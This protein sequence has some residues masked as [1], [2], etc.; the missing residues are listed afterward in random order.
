MPGTI[1][2]SA[3]G[4]QVVTCDAIG[5]SESRA[6]CTRGCTGGACRDE[7]VCGATIYETTSGGSWLV[8]L[9]GE[10]ADQDHT[11]ACLYHDQSP[12]GEDVLFRLE[13]DRTRTF[14]F[15]ARYS[16]GPEVIDPILYLR[17]RC[18]DRASQIWCHE[19]TAG[20]DE[21]FTETLAPGDYFLVI[22]R[23]ERAGTRCG[24]LDVSITPM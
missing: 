14:R 24:V 13:V 20:Q 1:R 15:Q 3:D 17:S 8:D 22:D 11:S 9:C 5:A 2:C 12:A 16:S 4:T 21:D 19:D 7:T 6:P 10:G 18:G 23:H